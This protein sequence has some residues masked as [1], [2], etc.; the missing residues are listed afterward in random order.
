MKISFRIHYQTHWGQQ[1]AVI[2]NNASLGNLDVQQAF[3]LNYIGDGFWEGTLS[4]QASDTIHYQYVLIDEFSRI[5]DQEWGALRTI[6]SP[7]KSEIWLFLRDTWRSKHAIENALY[8]SAFLNVIFK[9]TDFKE[10]T[11]SK[12]LKKQTISLQIRAARVPTKRQLCVLGSIPALGSW[13]YSRPLLLENSQFPFWTGQ[14]QHEL[15]APIEYKYGFYDPL[16]KRVIQLEAGENRTVKAD[17]SQ[18]VADQLVVTDEY[19]NLFSH[20]WKGA[21]VAIPVFSLRSKVGF[22]VGEFSDIKGLVDWAKQVKMQMIQLLPINDTTVTYS[23]VDSYPYAAISVFA[24]HPIYL[25]LEELPGFATVVDQARY[26]KERDRLNGLAV[27]D[28]EEVLRLKLQYARQLFEAEKTVFLQSAAFK[29]FLKKNQH[30][31]KPYSLFCYLRDKYGTV[32][33]QHWEAH[34]IYTEKSLQKYTNPKAENFD[35]IAFQYFL[36]FYLDLQLKAATAY[37][38]ENGVVLKGDIPIGIYRNSV[39]A[40]MAPHLFNMNGQ[41]GAPPDPFSATGQNWGFPTYNW[42]EMAKDGYLWWQNRLRQ[43]SAYFD[44]F[45][46]DHILGFFRIWEIPLGQ[47]DG[48]MGYFNPAIPI[49]LEEFRERGIPFE[50]D[51]FCKP[52]ITDSILLDLFGDKASEVIK[53]FLAPENGGKYQLKSGFD[54]QQKIRTYLQTPNGVSLK[55]LEKGLFDLVSNVLFFPVQDTQETVFHPRIDCQKTSSFQALDP[56]VQSRLRD[57]YNNYFYHRQED[58]W[59][60]QAMTKLPAIR[61]ATDMLICGEDLGMVP[62]CVPGVM[63]ALDFFSLEI[64]RMSKNPA[65]EFLQVEDIPYL[66]VCSP[67]TH[68]MSPIRAWW[69][70]SDRAQIQRF[71]HH[72]LAKDGVA[73]HTCESYICQAIFQQHLS[74]PSMW[75]VFPIQ[76]ILAVD[77]L[78]RRSNPFD[79]RIN[80]PSNPQHYWRYR[81]HLTLE[82]LLKEK[83]FNEWIRDM[84]LLANRG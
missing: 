55:E 71:Y 31:L 7:L 63:K 30:W 72:E 62:A 79:E 9:P 77:P 84:M 65:N 56:V 22:G 2:G 1:I 29:T 4:L 83:D 50:E 42:A 36:Q 75:A 80:V 73:P 24:L 70:E 59:K 11:K 13:D 46:I 20:P 32:D 28:Y 5:L 49:Q 15:L 78:L 14:F 10:T 37:G 69:E 54:N 67:S 68:D 16:A 60:E 35:E 52:Y 40:W 12:F 18:L 47:I 6:S 27:V 3:L 51:R 57:L 53:T 25:R 64:Q 33:F 41:A 21:G 43:L 45:R 19:L 44:A 74:W 8:N 23:W 34:R 39:D 38:R 48:T 81:L 82:D 17:G 26:Q 76:D 61:Q 66:S 58:F